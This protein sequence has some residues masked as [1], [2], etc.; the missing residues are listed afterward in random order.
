V[1]GRGAGDLHADAVA[2]PPGAAARFEFLVV[3]G[4]GNVIFHSDRFRN[5]NENFLT[6]TDGNRRLRDKVAALMADAGGALAS[7]KAFF[8]EHAPANFATALERSGVTPA[9]LGSGYV[10]F[11]TY[12][13]LL[14]A[15]S[16]VMALLV[17]RTGVTSDRD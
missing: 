17:M 2:D 3:D 6:E 1:A 8:S 15:F 13:A 4:D 12:S 14:G 9:A 10:V 5:T 16:L 11:F 7:F